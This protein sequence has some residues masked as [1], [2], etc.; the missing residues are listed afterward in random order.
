[1]SPTSSGGK[2]ET[3]YSDRFVPSRSASAGL[4]GFNLLDGGDP[5]A[6]AAHPSSEREVR[7]PTL[8]NV[9]L[10]DVNRRTIHSELAFRVF[11]AALPTS[12]R[13]DLPTPDNSPTPRGRRN[14]SQDT[15]ARVLDAPPLG[16]SRRRLR[17]RRGSYPR[18]DPRDSPPTPPTRASYSH[19]TPGRNL[20]RFKSEGA[21][22][23]ADSP[24]SLSPVGGDGPLGTNVSSPRR[25]P[26]KIA[27]SPFKV[28]DA[29]AL[30]DDFYLNLVD[31]RRITCSP[32]GSA[33]ASTS[34]P[35]ARRG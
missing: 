22:A 5:P 35:R 16:T 13:P 28:L 7:P 32:S 14:F 10:L 8:P 6:S 3:V 34:G 21:A 11:A 27:R 31:C 1:M 26:R 15:S 24:F 2:R 19:C 20:F 23:L 30:Q 12:R 4:Q 33:R 17:L 25:A 29:P 9:L 18:E